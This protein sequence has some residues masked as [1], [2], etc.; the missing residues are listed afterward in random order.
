MYPLILTISILYKLKFKK[1]ITHLELLN[2]LKTT[3]GLDD[4]MK[5]NV[6]VNNFLLYRPILKKDSIIDFLTIVKN[7]EFYYSN[8]FPKIYK[9]ICSNINAR[10]FIYENNSTDQTKKLLEKLEQKYNNIFIKTDIINDLPDGRVEKII[11]GRNNLSKFYKQTIFNKKQG[12]DYV[13]LFDTDII[14]NYETS[15]LPLLNNINYKKTFM[16]ASFTIFSG[17]NILLNNILNKHEKSNYD[18]KYIN[19]MLNYYYDLFALNYGELYRKNTLD[20][21]DNYTIKSV[22]TCFGGLV[23][24]RKDYYLTTF[25]DLKKDNLKKDNLPGIC[26]H[27]SFCDR[28]KQ[29]GNIFICKDSESLWYQ[30]RDYEN[31]KF[32]KYVI[33]FIKNKKL[34]NILV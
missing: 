30:D 13:F 8:V 27:W 6:L 22:E 18:I 10:F 1:N 5:H 34:N 9:D 21:F 24:I 23:L 29:Y 15:I 28:L 26:E 19:S 32:K 4:N 14:F 17:K 11:I 3:I 31:N 33:F 7:G 25:Y 2:I 16:L 20:F 12:G